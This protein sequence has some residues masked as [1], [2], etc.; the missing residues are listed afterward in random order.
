MSTTLKSLGQ[1]QI[2]SIHFTTMQHI[3]FALAII[4]FVSVSL[5]HATPNQIRNLR[6]I[7]GAISQGTIST[8]EQTVFQY[9]G[10]GVM[11]YL[12]FTGGY[13]PIEET[14]FTYYIDENSP[15]SHS[16]QFSY[17]LALGIGWGDQTAPWG[18]FETPLEQIS[19]LLFL[20]FL[21]Y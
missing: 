15:T 17:F 11:T 6:T 2:L 16:I 3:F 4:I 8:N 9:S 20:S 13:T 21:K 18:E 19:S 12:W 1:I 14:V 10:R 7:G 5:S